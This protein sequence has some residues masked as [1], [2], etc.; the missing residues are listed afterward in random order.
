MQ[1]VW[2]V[3]L[4]DVWIISPWNYATVNFLIYLILSRCF[5]T[6]DQFGSFQ[7]FTAIHSGMFPNKLYKFNIYY[8]DPWYLLSHCCLYNPTCVFKACDTCLFCSTDRTSVAVCLRL[9][10]EWHNVLLTHFCVILTHHEHIIIVLSSV[11]EV[12]LETRGRV[13]SHAN[14]IHTFLPSYLKYCPVVRPP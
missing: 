4:L 11:C 2:L 9:S 8:S 13:V 10:D 6:L 7:I 5:S 12:P 14:T 3:G 1:C